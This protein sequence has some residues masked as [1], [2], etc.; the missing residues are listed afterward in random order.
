MLLIPA[1]HLDKERLSVHGPAQHVEDCL[2]VIL[3]NSQL[4]R[5]NVCDVRYCVLRENHLEEFDEN[6]LVDLRSEN[7]FEAPV[8]HQVD[9][10]ALAPNLD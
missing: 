2:P 8:D 5:R 10:L 3:H 9:V 7:L 4:L 6:V 1:L